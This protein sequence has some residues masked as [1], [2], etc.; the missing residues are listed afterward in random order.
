[1]NVKR[2]TI[3][4]IAVVFLFIICVLISSGCGQQ[5][6]EKKEQKV[7]LVTAFEPFGEEKINPTELILEKLPEEIGEYRI[8]KLLLPVE[9]VT[10]REIAFAEYDQLKPDAVIMMGQNGGSDSIHIETTG[11][12]VM[13]AVESDG[14]TDPDNAGFAPDN[15]PVV[16]GGADKLYSTFPV[17]EIV[18][19]V[20]DEGVKCEKSDDAGKFVCNTLLYGMLE[21][22]NGEVP[23]GFIHVPFLKEQA[24]EGEP[25]MEL[26]DMV[27][28]I[29]A[30]VKTVK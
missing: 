20:N 10:S 21:H 14:F 24:Y 18:Q 1:M 30:A 4:R 13:N 27:K 17:D 5:G 9:F 15:E 2:K 11:V 7:I 26:D 12:N 25:Y 19:A 29:V 8:E 28:G 16:E 6:A 3:K 23:T 22:N